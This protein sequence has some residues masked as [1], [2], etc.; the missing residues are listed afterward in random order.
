MKKLLIANWKLHYGPIKAGA[1]IRAFRRERLPK[2]VDIAVAV[3]HVSMAAARAS[4]GRASIPALAAQD[5]FWADEGAFTGEISP[6]MLAEFGV[7]YC[8]VGHS[9]RRT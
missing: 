9:E 1:W 2:D 3:P 6:A 8:L 4:L 7:Q 5:A